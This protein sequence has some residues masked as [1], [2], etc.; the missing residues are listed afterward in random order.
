MSEVSTYVLSSI[1]GC[2]VLNISKINHHISETK[3]DFK[4][5]ASSFSMVILP[6]FLSFPLGE[7]HLFPIEG[8]KTI[9]GKAVFF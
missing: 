1:Y 5:R 8:D 6:V 2:R 3:A 4:L 7:G 9:L